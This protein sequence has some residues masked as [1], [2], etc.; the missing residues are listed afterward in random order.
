M[1]YRI[2]GVKTT[3]TITVAKYQPRNPTNGTV[4]IP[5]LVR[6]SMPS[7]SAQENAVAEQ[8]SNQAT[9]NKR[10][11]IMTAQAVNLPNLSITSMP[12]TSK[13]GIV[14]LT[15]EEEPQAKR[16]QPQAQRLYRLESSNSTQIRPVMSLKPI[17]ES[18]ISSN[19]S[20]KF[21]SNYF[22][23][24]SEAKRYYSITNSICNS[25]YSTN[26]ATSEETIDFSSSR[27]N[28]PCDQTSADFK[29][30]I[31]ITKSSST[32]HCRTENSNSFETSGAT[33]GIKEYSIGSIV[34]TNSTE[35]GYSHQ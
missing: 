5:N 32:K 17:G 34:E 21:L 6:Q 15:D 29:R 20:Q 4:N 25:S 14:D 9:A 23:S 31:D 1:K 12:G 8:Q 18:K 28:E 7:I 27:S 16:P 24:S 35:T 3:K 30:S 19:F 13:S 11:L 22:I 2:N 33:S 26:S 10:R